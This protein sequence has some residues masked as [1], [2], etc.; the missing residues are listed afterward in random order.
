[1]R[2]EKGLA[3][4]LEILLIGLQHAVEPGKKLLCAVIR[5][6]NDG[7]TISSSHLTDVLGTLQQECT[8][9]S[10][11]LAILTISFHPPP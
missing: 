4:L 8:E 11:F 9:I 6:H 7:N 2:A 10:V 3:V 5:V 1:V